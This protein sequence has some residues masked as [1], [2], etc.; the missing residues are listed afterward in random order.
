MTLKRILL[1]TDFSETAQDAVEYARDLAA[2]YGATLHLLYVIPDPHT[3]PWAGAASGIVIPDLLTEW[4]TEARGQL[5][6]I[7][8]GDLSTVRVTRVGH[9]FVE[10]VRYAKEHEIDLVVMG[11]HGRG[12]VKHMLLGSVAEKVVRTAPCPVLTV[13]HQGHTFV[14]P[15]MPI[16]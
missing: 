14:M 11:T 8:L 10:I 4:E 12:A 16:T 5:A 15:I 6:A 2:G 1:P 13:R 9:P 3:Q 7:E